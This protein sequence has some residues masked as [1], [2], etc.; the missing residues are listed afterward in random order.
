MPRGEICNIKNCM[1]AIG[2]GSAEI[3]FEIEGKDHK[4]RACPTHTGILMTAP[5]GTFRITPDHDLE[6]IPAQPIILDL[7]R[8]N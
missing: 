2:P 3:T 8:K 5:R 1:E 7:K 4:L 6:R